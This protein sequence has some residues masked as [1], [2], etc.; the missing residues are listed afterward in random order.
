VSSPDIISR[1]FI[2][3]K[4]HDDLVNQARAEVRRMF[5]KR[6]ASPGNAPV[7]WSKFKLKMRDEISDLLYSKTKRN[8]MV[9][10]VIVEV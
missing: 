1:G 9:L 3:M 10:P 8:P 2:L 4:E 6:V 5:E 7:D